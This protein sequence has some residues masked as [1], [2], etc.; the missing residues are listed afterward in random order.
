MLKGIQERVKMR[1]IEFRG[2]KKYSDEWVFGNLGSHYCRPNEKYYYI[3]NCDTDDTEWG[4]NRDTI[5]QYTGIKDKNGKKIFE[6]DIVKAHYIKNVNATPYERDFVIKEE[7]EA[8]GKVIYDGGCF[9]VKWINLFEPLGF[10]S[11]PVDK[12]VNG[13]S[14]IEYSFLKEYRYEFTL[15]KLRVM[16][17]IYDNPEL[18]GK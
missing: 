2:K 7:F 1:E 17:N 10:N 18:I 4:I 12:Y 9:I 8:I 14:S 5:G 11:E 15:D 6:G 16:G 3:Y 13:A